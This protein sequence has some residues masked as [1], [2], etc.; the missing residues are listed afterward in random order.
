M[1][2]DVSNIKTHIGKEI[3]RFFVKYFRSECVEQII[4]KG[5]CSLAVL[6][7]MHEYVSSKYWIVVKYDP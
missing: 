5:D 7:G 2:D 1:F 3:I 6:L 4:N